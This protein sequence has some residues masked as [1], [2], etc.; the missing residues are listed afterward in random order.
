MRRF[1]ACDAGADGDKNDRGIAFAIA[2][3]PASLGWKW[4]PLSYAGSIRVGCAE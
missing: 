3:M 2:C 4:S 1:G